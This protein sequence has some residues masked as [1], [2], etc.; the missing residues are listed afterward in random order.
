MDFVFNLND[1]NI[2]LRNFARKKE[3]IVTRLHFVYWYIRFEDDSRNNL[4]ARWTSS[5]LD[6]KKS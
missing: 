6:R 5:R 2:P 1:G 3:C 4:L